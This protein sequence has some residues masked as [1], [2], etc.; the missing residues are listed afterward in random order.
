VTV[1]S[2]TPG[3]DRVVKALGTGKVDNAWLG[4][5]TITDTDITFPAGFT[6]IAD[7]GTG[8]AIGSGPTEKLGLWGATPVVQPSGAAQAALTDSIAGTVADAIAAI[9][10]PAD[11]PLTADALRDD[12]VTNVLPKIRDALSSLISRH[13]GVRN[14]VVL[15]GL[16][17]GSA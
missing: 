17:K 7:T 9:P 1:A 16:L 14:G 13:N 12:L 6:L 4:F 11:T 5:A 3:A 8:L 2:S 10:D 15:T